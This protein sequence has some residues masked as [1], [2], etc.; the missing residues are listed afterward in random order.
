[1][2]SENFNAPNTNSLCRGECVLSVSPGWPCQLYTSSQHH[3][4]RV[5]L[6]KGQYQEV[7]SIMLQVAVKG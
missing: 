3:L 5:L 2:C 6:F 1:M 7:Y 4:S